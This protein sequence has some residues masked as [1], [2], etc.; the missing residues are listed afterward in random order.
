M[1]RDVSNVG[2]KSGATAWMRGQGEAGMLTESPVRPQ[3]VRPKTNVHTLKKIRDDMRELRV[4]AGL[5]QYR[6]R[7]TFD[8]HPAPNSF[9]F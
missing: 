8:P 2:H 6:P 5:S 9:I 1:I 4:C 3:A 7:N